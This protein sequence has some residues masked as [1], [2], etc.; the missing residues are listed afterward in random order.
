MAKQPKGELVVVAGGFDYSPLEAGVAE[1]ARSAAARIREKVKRSVEN[2]IDVGN[3]L[4][5]AKQVLPHGQFGLWLDAEFGWAERTARN[6]MVVAERFG[7]KSAIIADL[8]IDPTA[9]YLL[10]APSVPE[11][12]VE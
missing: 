5:A 7:A 11:Q 8:P 10:A 12:A 6:F 3:D 2:I 4:L 9:A 1:K